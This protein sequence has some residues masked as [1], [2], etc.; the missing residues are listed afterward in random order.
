MGIILVLALPFCC[1]GDDGNQADPL[2]S[3]ASNITAKSETTTDQTATNQTATNQT[4]TGQT[5]TGQTANAQENPSG[6]LLLSKEELEQEKR[7]LR[8]MLSTSI[9]ILCGFFL[10]VFLI[11]LLR[12]GQRYRRAHLSSRGKET[13]ELFDAWSNYRLDEDSIDF[14]EPDDP[15]QNN[16]NP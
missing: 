13:T 15:N 3:P 5:A 11:T 7:K 6:K 1:L 10:A 9:I 14:D 16:K 2:D 12:I 8:L 4:A